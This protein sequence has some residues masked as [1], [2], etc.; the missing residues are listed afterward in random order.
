MLLCLSSR[1]YLI[2]YNLQ[3]IKCGLS[4]RQIQVSVRTNRPIDHVSVSKSADWKSVGV[5]IFCSFP[6]MPLLPF[7]IK[8]LDHWWSLLKPQ[9]FHGWIWRFWGSP[10]ALLKCIVPRHEWERAK[11]RIK[12]DN[13]WCT[14]LSCVLGYLKACNVCLH[15]DHHIHLFTC[16]KQKSNFNIARDETTPWRSLQDHLRKAKQ[17]LV[18]VLLLFWSTTQT[19][20]LNQPLECWC[21][22]KQTEANWSKLKQTQWYSPNSSKSQ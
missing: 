20:P 21:K 18:H 17:R 15:Y 19:R 11:W 1:T 2:F 16:W 7:P 22:L 9:I 14:L 10:F 13:G 5:C 4:W 12:V 8:P 6:K 3:G